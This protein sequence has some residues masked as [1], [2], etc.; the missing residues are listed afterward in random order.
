[1]QINISV[2]SEMLGQLF[3]V[4]QYSKSILQQLN[5]RRVEHTFEE[6]ELFGKHVISEPHFAVSVQQMLVEVVSDTSTEVDLTE[7]VPH[8]VP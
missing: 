1:M 2:I 8:C 4:R 3:F 7:H 5:R 6:A